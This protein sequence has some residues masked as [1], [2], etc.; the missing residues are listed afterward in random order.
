[1]NQ[2]EKK[3]FEIQSDFEPESLSSPYDDSFFE[4]ALAGHAKSAQ[5]PTRSFVGSVVSKNRF[6]FSFFIFCAVLMLFFG[7][8][9][10]MQILKGEE[11]RAL[12]EENRTRIRV[13]PAKRG[14]IYDRH[15]TILA[16]ND[17]TFQLITS[18]EQLPEDLAEQNQF[19]QDLAA[20]MELEP[21]TLTELVAA[22]ENPKEQIL[23]ADDISYEDA[24]R[25]AA[26][27]NSFPGV[28]I[29][30]GSRRSYITDTIPSLS[31]LIGYTGIVNM[32]EFEAYRE[33]GYRR[34][35]LIGKQGLE[36]QYESLLRGTF[37]QEILEVD[38]LGQT[39]RI[40]SRQDPVDGQ[41][42]HLTIDAELQKFIEQSIQKHLNEVEPSKASVI[43]MDPHTGE[44]FALV[45]WPA[46][47]ANLFT[48][49]IDQETYQALIEDPDLP[50]FARA[51]AGEF[52]SG[53]SIKPV[54][55]AGAL[56]DDII[57]PATSFVSTGGINIG[58]WFFPDWRAGGHGVT[59]IYHAIAD[60]VNTFFYLI[61]GGNETFTGMGIQRLMEHA[62]NFGFGQPT[63]ID[64]PGEADGF[65]PSKEW[66]IREKGEVWY[67]GDTYHTAI[68]QGDFLS[69]P[70]QIARATAVFANRGYS[71]VPH[72]NS[73]L[74]VVDQQILPPQE[75]AIV[76]EAMRRTVTR[77][78]AQQLSALPVTS[79]G[80]TGTAQWSSIHG[81]HA[82]YT[83]FAPFED[84]EIAFT[85]LVEEGAED[86]LAVPIA[87]DILRWW[88]TDSSLNES[89]VNLT[90]ELEEILE[91]VDNSL[92]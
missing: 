32:K 33:S 12:A 57:T 16:K 66:K 72:L 44:I 47:D 43:V 55:A 81:N 88:F 80:K 45:S 49:G 6:R 41:N 53:S 84:P 20:F 90:T 74:E 29:E 26:N 5:E 52:P 22:A 82:W 85:V 8:A 67:I 30:L 39:E 75:T 56:A 73:D 83:G 62:A 79:A 60:S 65:L 35:D 69:T 13:I 15:G 17:P 58:P 23:M 2:S 71:V 24:L 91:D 89:E 77:G 92:N 42:L 14:V 28:D 1:M 37:G 70:L 11:Y 4:E 27:E 46:F 7:K 21:A 9:A 86:F 25:F 61:G 31:H 76:A 10:S 40:V 87:E 48:T 59:N 63:G 19:I 51:F 34:F 54:F 64:L 78:T 50:L 38:A 3:L 18:P 36:R 68:G